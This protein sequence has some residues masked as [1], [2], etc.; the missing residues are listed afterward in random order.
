MH[1]R[2]GAHRPNATPSVYVSYVFYAL[3]GGGAVADRYDWKDLRERLHRYP[4]Y[5]LGKADPTGEW[6]PWPP[7]PSA[8]HARRYAETGN[9]LDAWQSLR[10]ALRAGG[11][12]ELQPEVAAYFTRCAIAL[13]RLVVDY[14]RDEVRRTIRDCVFEA[15]ELAKSGRGTPFADVGREMWVDLIGSFIDYWVVKAPESERLSP[16][17]A[18]ARI[19]DDLGVS[20][21]V[22]KDAY[23]SY[24]EP[25][26]EIIAEQEARGLRPR[27]RRRKG[28]K[29]P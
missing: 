16:S 26:R 10:A 15:L 4:R 14:P 28:A 29:L 22:A 18:A 1:P 5:P 8:H 24:L 19:A 20:E 11:V 12:V 27:P 23:R 6:P 25:R 9:P 13:A 7:L 3:S 17:A 2:N 21:T